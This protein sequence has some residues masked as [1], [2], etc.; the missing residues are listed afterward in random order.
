MILILALTLLSACSGKEHEETAPAESSEETTEPIAVVEFN[1]D[2]IVWEI[3]IFEGSGEETPYNIFYTN[4]SPFLVTRI[5]VRFEPK[6][7]MTPEQQEAFA[8]YDEEEMAQIFISGYNAHFASPGEQTVST[9]CEISAS[10]LAVTNPMQFEAM[11]PV[12]ITVFYM[13]SDGKQ[14]KAVKDLIT[15]ECTNEIH[16]ENPHQWAESE[17]GALIPEPDCPVITSNISID[18][19]HAIMYGATRESFE[20]YKSACADAGFTENIRENDAFY[21]ADNADGIKL[22]L[23]FFEND[24][25]LDINVEKE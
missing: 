10:G 14:Y 21:G 17:L 19:F 22:S 6:A 12:M 23:Y 15:G 25:E 20:E 9:P 1:P 7:E 3:E 5:E 2:D 4:N 18:S 11:E 8:I 13:G 24:A 16:K